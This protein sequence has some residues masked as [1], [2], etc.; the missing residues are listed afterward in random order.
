VLLLAGALLV[1]AIGPATAADSTDQITGNGRTDSAVTVSWAQG[2]LGADNTTVVAPRDPNSPLS[3]LAQDFQ[4]LSVTVSQ[5]RS[6]V[7]QSVN[8][9][10]TGGTNGGFL[11]LMQ[12][13]GDAT[14]GPNPEDCEFGTPD[15][16]LRSG[17][18]NA[19]AGSRGGAVCAAG[20]VPSTVTPPKN[21]DGTGASGGCDTG[22]P[23]DPSHLDPAAND[24]QDWFVPFVPVGTDQRIYND[25]A[26][27]TGQLS[28]FF[29]Q[30]NTNEVQEGD[31]GTDGTGQ[32]FFQTLTGTE[33]PGLGCGAVVAGGAPRGCWLVIVPRGRFD[34]NGFQIHGSV[35]PVDAVTGSP[36]GASMW[37][38]R[39][40]IHLGFAP[41]ATNCPIGSAQERETVGTELVAHAVFSWQLALNA[42]ADCRTLYGY[43]SVP[44]PTST[45]QLSTT[46]GA[47]L[48]FTSV[49]IGSEVTR[50]GG[51][52]GTGPPLV[53]APVTASAITFG[54]NV[55]LSSSNGFDPTPIKL[56]PRL[57]AKSLTQS[58]KT[59]L[60][61]FDSDDPGPAW[62]RHNPINITQDPEF[63]RLNPTVSESLGAPV[64]P[65]ITE[66]HSGINQQ[67]WRWILADP[68]ARA[69]L[70][71][72]VDE[73]GMVVNPNYLALHLGSSALDSFPR[74]DPTCFN[75]H[76]PGE[77][78]ALRCTLDLLP[79][80]NNL[81]DGAAHVRASDN[82]EGA[83]WDPTA[84]APNGSTGWWGKGGLEPS[85]S[86]FLWTMTDSASLANYG[87]V[88]A[89]LCA[90]NGSA[91]VGPNSASVGTA[92]A[93]A[94][95]DSAGL[96][97]V[98]PAAPGS[99][100]YP[101][102]DVT[103]AA[104]RTTGTAAALNDFAALIAYAA[105]PGQIP[106]VDPGQLPHGYL[107]LP[108][109]L[110]SQASA[111]A[112]TLRADALAKPPMSSSGPGGTPPSPSGGGVGGSPSG[113]GTGTSGG[114]QTVR[115]A[116]KGLP[117]GG[118]AA[119]KELPATL[120]ARRTP[121][122][123]PGAV[124]WVL[125]V[126]G[127]VGVVGALGGGLLRLRR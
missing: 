15:N 106:G 54:F 68:A 57:L 53:Y 120:A 85:R 65:L 43:S 12:C 93:A 49:P 97:H 22:E 60:T 98:N 116:A 1:T 21:A 104:V 69:W 4:H 67:V 31:T 101:L 124:R 74:A 83:S 111:A 59:D 81:D 118:P 7:H 28:D 127:I 95:P 10:W 13:Y 16:L 6:L 47:G 125:L 75:Q 112:A 121:G 90:A 27:G 58:Y 9:S 62:A 56:T 77:G 107:P 100:G 79:Y 110:R 29:D 46:D 70:G 92:L 48:A 64:A 105:G 94:K 44:E 11:Q 37:A 45:K 8:V 14:T 40:Q 3:F 32:N 103:Y 18:V 73:T 35:A 76:Q 20:S 17:L 91:C 99:G 24:P 80:V 113:S 86:T 55:N 122:G 34:A 33:A 30:F 84:A 82:P 5:T 88:P 72:K 66:D 126:V 41:V 23:A 117:A 114:Q 52:A 61:D 78:T 89:R 2:L 39:I 71:G 42:A 109:R 38:Q 119:T 63:Q 26:T 87:L 19:S 102:V 115:Q 50:S 36:L 25:A 96:L 123:L 51:V 108:N